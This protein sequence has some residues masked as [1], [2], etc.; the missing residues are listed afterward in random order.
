[1]VMGEKYSK[2]RKNVSHAAEPGFEP[3]LSDFRILY[4]NYKKS[5]YLVLFPV[6]ETSKLEMFLRHRSSVCR[7]PLH[8]GVYLTQVCEPMR[9]SSPLS[10]KLG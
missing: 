5:A 2:N 10:V 7:P 9:G 1:M 8:K 6:P 4:P 3:R